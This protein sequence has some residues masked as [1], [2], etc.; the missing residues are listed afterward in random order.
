MFLRVPDTDG[1]NYWLARH[2]AGMPLIDIA[3]LFTSS[4]EVQAKYGGLTKEQFLTKVYKNALGRSYDQDGYNYWKAK[5][6]SGEIG[7]GYL[8]LLFAGSTEHIRRTKSATS[9]ENCTEAEEVGAAPIY[10]GQP[11]YSTDLDADSDGIACET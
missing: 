8:L 7:R 9:F 2:N 5:L 3:E 10:K 6:D 11:G 4:A 1:F